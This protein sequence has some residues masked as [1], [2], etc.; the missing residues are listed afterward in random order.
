[1]LAAIMIV[2]LL[3]ILPH[4]PLSSYAPLSTAVYAEDGELLRLTL[5]SDQQ[6][7]LWT[8]L[9]EVSPE[10]VDGLLLHEDRHFLWHFGVDPVALVRAVKNMAG[11]GP[12]Q[13]GSTITMQLARLIYHLNTRSVPGKLR[14]MAAATWLE[15]RYSKREILE[16][17]INLTPY[18]HNVQG[19]G[20]ASR[21]YLDKSAAK[22]TFAE[23][24]ALALIP[25]SPNLR[26]PD[27]EEPPSLKTARINLARLWATQHPLSDAS[28]ASAGKTLHFRGLHQLPFEAPHLVS[29]L[30]EAQGT[31][32]DTSPDTSHAEGHETSH[33]IHATINLPLQ[34]LL[35]RT[36]Q[37]YIA[38]QRT[39]GV[40]NAAAM[41]VDYRTMRVKGLVGSADFFDASIDGQV[42]GTTAKRSPGSALKPFI[43]ALAMDQG[44]IHTQSM[45]KDAPTAFGAY[46]PENFDGAFVGPV[47]VHDAL[48]AS[49]NV[50]AVSL[51]AKLAQ[52]DL[53]Q[54]LRNAGISHLASERHYGL[55]LALGGGEVTME[56]L[57][58]LY[59][60][61]G[62]RGTL[63][64]LQYTLP[65]A[66]ALPEAA[67]APQTRTPPQT[68]RLP[69]ANGAT[70]R[71]LSDA[72]AFMVLSILKDNPRPDGLANTHPQ[73]A[74]KTGTS[75]GFR[76]AWSVGIFGPY[77]LAVWV[78]NFDGS[79]NP[80][81][82]GVQMAAP[83]F[84]HIV[85]GMR[86]TDLRIPEAPD[87][88]PAGVTSVEVCAGSGDLPNAECPH[89]TNAW[90]IP[91]K[92]PI[93][94]SSVHRRIL[95][96]TRT[97]LRACA[98]T[99]PRYTRADVFE[100][101]P[102]DILR[103]YALAGMPRRPIPADRCGSDALPAG[104]VVPAILYPRSGATYQLHAAEFGRETL[105]LSA[106][107]GTDIASLYWFADGAYVGT[108]PP[109]T[110]LAWAP[111]HAG[112]VNL[113]VVDDRGDTAGRNIRVA[114]IP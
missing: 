56:E 93:R 113:S 66:A 38:T 81:L 8:P 48:I 43:Y 98:D 2:V 5:A 32:Q 64:P 94:V 27:G 47:S 17:H 62:N 7:R 18:G 41:L 37:Q 90:F 60:M 70:N 76:D 114:V 1:V 6:Y 57:V 46:A 110:A 11:G 108:S 104:E 54:F 34:H 91:G 49:R 13:G 39:L 40:T 52:P 58:T 14:Q 112:E 85:D 105:Q 24:L 63:A 42:N 65:E 36:L 79:S 29:E 53:Y 101:W 16:A 86:A 77:V 61:L 109:S 96:D 12:H 26:D 83:L 15:L 80:A 45:L 69:A 74:W 78:G 67:T 84:F 75:W 35:E 19:I 23:A 99:P 3:R 55:A 21:I 73:V 33:A 95:I 97:G 25:Q 103:L 20:A 51:A 82:V 9:S 102:S 28:L 107:A 4:A 89:R 72:A 59:A 22:L 92:S 31:S 106:T 44:L 87:S 100:A 71:V 68:P 88:P 50:P 111:T 10:F 30:L